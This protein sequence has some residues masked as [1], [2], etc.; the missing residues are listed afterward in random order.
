M[1]PQIKFLIRR[2]K[3]SEARELAAFALQSESSADIL[4]RCADLV[5]A[6]APE[7]FPELR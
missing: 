5:H 2:L 7:L 3:I 1:V 6:A 4:S